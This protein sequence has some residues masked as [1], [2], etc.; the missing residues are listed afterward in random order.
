MDRLAPDTRD[1]P[2]PH[3]DTEDT[4]FTTPLHPTSG[5]ATARL[6]LHTPPGEPDHAHPRRAPLLV[7]ME[8][9]PNLAPG[10]GTICEYLGLHLRAITSLADIPQVLDE[11]RPLAIITEFEGTYQDGGDVLKAVAT[12]DPNLPV[13]VLTNQD[14]AWQGATEALAETLNLPHVEIPTTH[15]SLGTIVDFL[16]RAARH[17]R[18]RRLPSRAG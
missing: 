16:T 9:T 3:N 7:V 14:A 13:M 1:H 10:L 12:H 11:Y 5:F 15:P 18:N 8:D 17:T 2:L 4:D 6:A